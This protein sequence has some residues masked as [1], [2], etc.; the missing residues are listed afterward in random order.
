MNQREAEHPTKYRLCCHPPPG[1]RKQEAG[2]AQDTKQ[3]WHGVTGQETGLFL[4]PHSSEREPTPCPL[5]PQA[6][7]GSTFPKGWGRR[8]Q[9]KACQ[10]PPLSMR[11]FLSPSP[12]D[13]RRKENY[14]NME[15]KK[16]NTNQFI[17]KKDPQTKKTN[18]WLPKQKGEGEG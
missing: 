6:G 11:P 15:S 7:A 17:Y 8:E 14:Q 13:W 9:R 10:K 2:N 4:H 5:P 16:N 1:N 3:E 18:L 12:R